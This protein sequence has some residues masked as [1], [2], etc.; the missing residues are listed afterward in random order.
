M[1]GKIIRIEAFRPESRTEI[2]SVRRYGRPSAWTF[3]LR[4]LKLE[5]QSGNLVTRMILDISK[6]RLPV[7]QLWLS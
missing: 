3:A 7:K 2:S 4:H 6:L 5:M 1:E